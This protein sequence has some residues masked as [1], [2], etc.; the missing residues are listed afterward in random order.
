[1]TTTSN[2]S[3]TLL[4]CMDR[5][6]MEQRIASFKLK[7]LQTRDNR[8]ENSRLPSFLEEYHRQVAESGTIPDQETYINTY[9]KRNGYEGNIGVEARGRRAFSS[10]VRE[11]HLGFVLAEHFT[12]EPY[13]MALDK[14]YGIDYVITEGGKRFF[15]HA[16]VDTPQSNYWRARK[17]GR[18]PNGLDGIHIDISINPDNARRV[19]D[20][21]LYDERQLEQVK[22]IVH[23]NDRGY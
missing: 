15:V 5:K 21:W 2:T 12:V 23:A 16:F 9:L 18:H 19:G 1:M 17:E 22:R 4:T 8:A 13:S 3:G 6:T 14:E 10:L 20:F 7:F 11:H